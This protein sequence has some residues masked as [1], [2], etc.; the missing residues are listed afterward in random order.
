MVCLFGNL[1][2]LYSVAV[3]TLDFTEVDFENQNPT[4]SKLV[5]QSHLVEVL[6][7]AQNC[8]IFTL[9]ILNG[10]FPIEMKNEHLKK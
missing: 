9:L 1:G 6:H 5:L 7:N 2:T 3:K 8:S 4:V 10:H